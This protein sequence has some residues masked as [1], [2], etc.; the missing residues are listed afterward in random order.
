M[1]LGMH[2]GSGELVNKQ[3]DG[4]STGSAITSEVRSYLDPPIENYRN[5]YAGKIKS[6]NASR[7]S[8]SVSPHNSAKNFF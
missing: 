7:T 2:G 3:S 6:P 4:T 8:S 5:I 1:A